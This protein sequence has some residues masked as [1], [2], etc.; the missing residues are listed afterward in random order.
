VS[1]KR[2][3]DTEPTAAYAALRAPHVIDIVP[4]PLQVDWIQALERA[5]RQAE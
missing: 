5:A 4:A 1:D 2:Q 3:T